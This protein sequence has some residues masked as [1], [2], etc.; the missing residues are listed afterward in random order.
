MILDDESMNYID[1]TGAIVLINVI[2]EMQRKKIAFY[3]SG[4]IG[5][6]RDIIYKCGIIDVLGEEN[7]FVKTHEAV[8]FIE[9]GE[10]NDEMQ[11]RVA[12]QNKPEK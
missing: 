6:T 7:L 9:T 5:P 11:K 8:N 3:I 12:R 1:S 2:K 4:A 10:R